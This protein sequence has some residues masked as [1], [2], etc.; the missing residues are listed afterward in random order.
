MHP[1]APATASGPRPAPAKAGK[2]FMAEVIPTVEVI[3]EVPCW[4]FLKRGS[5]GHIGFASPLPCQVNHGSVPDRIGSEGDLLDAI[6]LGQRLARGTRLRVAVHG[7][8]GLTGRG[9]YDDKLVCS[10]APV[11]AAARRGP[12]CFFRAYI[13]AKRM[14]NAL[15]VRAIDGHCAGWG[16]PGPALAR[17]PP[18]NADWRGPRALMSARATPCRRGLQP[19]RSRTRAGCASTRSRARCPRGKDNVVGKCN[20]HTDRAPPA[21]KDIPAP[22]LRSR[23]P[24]YD[25]GSARSRGK[26]ARRAGPLAIDPPR[27]S[28]CPHAIDNPGP[29]A[30]PGPQ[31]LRSSRSP[32]PPTRARS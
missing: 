23:K 13:A 5:T 6:V 11:P 26:P 20:H 9:G 28:P 27:E 30:P 22:C 15:R 1:R 21:R 31:R 25:P 3:V 7:A 14:L 17:A 10:D 19:T 32:G 16:A 4:S 18:R 8:I 12:V 24:G 2:P 29:A